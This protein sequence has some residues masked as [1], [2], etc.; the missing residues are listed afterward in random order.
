V[1]GDQIRCGLRAP[2]ET[3]R[4][5]SRDVWYLDE[6]V[7]TLN[8]EKRWLWRAVDQDGYAL[9]EIVQARRD[10]KAA[11]RSLT[12][13]LRKQGCLPKRVITDKLRSYGAAKC[14]RS[15]DSY[16]E[17]FRPTSFCPFRYA[18]R[19]QSLVGASRV[20]GHRGTGVVRARIWRARIL[21]IGLFELP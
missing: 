4:P 19:S 8:G 17:T 1:L 10:T 6:V 5:S 15:A 11:K 7:I 2:L 9:D 21:S 14:R 13:L 20:G 12:R 18:R 3:Q 16:D